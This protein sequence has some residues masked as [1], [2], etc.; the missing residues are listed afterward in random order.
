LFLFPGR[1]NRRITRLLR[2]TNR[3]DPYENAFGSGAELLESI[4]APDIPIVTEIVWRLEQGKAPESRRVS[5]ILAQASIYSS[6][7]DFEAKSTIFS[8]RH[9]WNGAKSKPRNSM[10]AQ[11][12]ALPPSAGDAMISEPVF[13]AVAKW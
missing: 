11:P 13:G 6:M 9:L 1:V 10:L 2:L 12:L 8:S 7:R 3:D 5:G 4:H